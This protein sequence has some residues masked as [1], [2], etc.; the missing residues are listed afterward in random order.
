MAD[1]SEYSEYAL[2]EDVKE[3]LQA[4]AQAIHDQVRAVRPELTVQMTFGDRSLA[5]EFDSPVDDKLASFWNSWSG[6]GHFGDGFLKDGDG[7]V[8]VSYIE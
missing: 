2:P 3:Q 6:G 5:P 8:N 1:R 4:T 7:F